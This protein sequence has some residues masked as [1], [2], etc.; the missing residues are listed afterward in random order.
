MREHIRLVDATHNDGVSIYIHSM[1]EKVI[2]FAISGDQL[3]RFRPH[4]PII[5]EHIHRASVVLI[6]ISTHDSNISIYGY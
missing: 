5:R 6:S 3:G 4:I 1:P 2:G